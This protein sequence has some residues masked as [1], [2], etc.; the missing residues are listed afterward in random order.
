MILERVKNAT[1]P[2]YRPEIPE[3]EA[4]GV[5]PQIMTLMKQCWAEDVSER[6]SFDEIVKTLQSINKGKLALHLI[7]LL[8]TILLITVSVSQSTSA[9]STQR[10]N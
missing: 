4:A 10:R 5:N 6:P 7:L 1:G 9:Y 8:I 2:S 3:H